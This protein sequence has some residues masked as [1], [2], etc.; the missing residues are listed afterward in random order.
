[1]KSWNVAILDV[2][3]LF[4]FVITLLLPAVSLGFVAHGIMVS[5]GKESEFYVGEGR[6][7]IMEFSEYESMSVRELSANGSCVRATE[8]EVKLDEG[9]IQEAESSLREGLSLNFEVSLLIMIGRNLSSR[10]SYI[11][12]LLSIW[13]HNHQIIQL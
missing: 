9:N 8:L 7:M 3:S 12:K 4:S 11:V 5:K 2:F 6:E 1:M 13:C 10:L